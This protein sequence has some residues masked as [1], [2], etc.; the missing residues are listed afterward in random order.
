MNKNMN[1]NQTN[2]SFED[3]IKNTVD[4]LLDGDT[5]NK[6]IED[7][8][9]E[10][11]EKAINRSFEYGELADAI[12]KKIKSILV[13]YIEN[14]NIS[15]LNIKLDTILTDIVNSTTLVE[16]KKILENFRGLMTEIPEKTVSLEDI[17]EVYCNDMAKN[18]NTVGMSVN[19]NH[20]HAI[21]PSGICQQ[22][23]LFLKQ[24]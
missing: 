5:V 6:V 23:I 13:P 24:N 19:T 20:L 16:N 17:F 10:S 8:M 12:S 22:T 14:C 21:I 11:I 3:Q 1:N 18:V 2:C 9:R 4:N 7:C 15:E